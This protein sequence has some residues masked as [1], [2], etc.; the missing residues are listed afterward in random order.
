MP[1]VSL[2]WIKPMMSGLLA[3]LTVAAGIRAE[4]PDRQGRW[5]QR[6]DRLK[7]LQFI[8]TGFERSLFYDIKPL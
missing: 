2:E 6:Q 3:S 4:C 1:Q 7:Q 5:F 8:R